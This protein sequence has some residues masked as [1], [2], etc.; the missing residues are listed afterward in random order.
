MK[1]LLIQGA[2]LKRMDRWIGTNKKVA[3]RLISGKRQHLPATKAER[4][5]S[6]SRVMTMISKEAERKQALKL[7]HYGGVILYLGD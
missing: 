1:A 5:E 3:M 7:S 2:F 4:E 6:D